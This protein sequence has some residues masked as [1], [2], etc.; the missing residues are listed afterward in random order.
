MRTFRLTFAL[1]VTSFGASETIRFDVSF[2]TVHAFTVGWNLYPLGAPNTLTA[3]VMPD[4]PGQTVGLFDVGVSRRYAVN[5][6]L[7]PSCVTF[8]S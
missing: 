3:R 8:A 6:C 4:V 1:T 2:G 5:T 7:S